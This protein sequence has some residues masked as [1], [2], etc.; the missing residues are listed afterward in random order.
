M[1]ISHG[2]SAGEAPV[3]KY[4]AIAGAT[5]AFEPAA[6]CYLAC[7]G[8]GRVFLARFPVVARAGA[9]CA[10]AV[11]SQGAITWTPG[12]CTGAGGA[13]PGCV[14]V[15]GTEAADTTAAEDIVQDE[16]YETCSARR[17]EI[18]PPEAI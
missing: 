16:P 17:R 5:R 12:S 14:E 9:A 7:G 11:L 10:A 2:P 1:R 4:L 13:C 8:S 15:P 3:M 6:W 18:P